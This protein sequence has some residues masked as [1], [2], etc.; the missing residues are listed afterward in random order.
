MNMAA[1]GHNQSIGA[2]GFSPFQWTR[3]SDAPDPELP[4]GIDPRKAFGGMLKLKAKAK[5]AFEMEYA[6][7]RMSKLSNATARP[8]AKF[9]TGTLVM[10][11]RQRMRPVK[12]SGH[13]VGPLRVLLQENN[14]LWLAT[15]ANIVKAKL[16]QVRVLTRREELQA[17]M[18]G[19]AVLK[20]PV[21]VESLLKDFTGKHYTNICGE[22]PSEQQRQMDVAGTTVLLEP[23]AKI[24]PDFWKFENGKWLIRIHNAPRLALFSPSR[25]T[26]IPMD[27]SNL[28]GL[29]RTYVRPLLEGAN[30]ML[31]ENNFEEVDDPHRLL[32]ER[33]I[34]ETWFEIKPKHEEKPKRSPEKSEQKDK[35][36][37]TQDDR[38][39]PGVFPEQAAPELDPQPEGD[40]LPPDGG[41][42]EA[43]H[44]KGPDAV[45]GVP[46][47][48]LGEA[49]SSTGTTCAI[50]DCVLP[51]GHYGPHM[52]GQNRRFG[53][54][55]YLGRT[56]WKDDQSSSDS[57]SSSSSD[58]ELISEKEM[59]RRKVDQ[60]HLAEKM[61]VEN[62]HHVYALEIDITSDDIKWISKHPQK[63]A[64]W[65][66][67]KVMEKGKEKQWRLLSQKEKLE[68]DE[69]QAKE[70]SQVLQSK[71]VRSLTC[72]EFAELDERTVMGMR[73]VLT[74][75]STGAAKARLV[76]LGYQAPGV[77][78]A[79]AASPTMSRLS[80]N[81]LFC[82]CAN[83]GF[84]VRGGD[85]TSAFLQVDDDMEGE[86]LTVWAPS[87][88]AVLFGAPPDNPVLPLRIL[89]AF[90]GLVTAP[91]AWF[92]HLARTLK[93][94]GWIQMSA[95]RCVFLLFD[96]NLPGSPLVSI[97]GVHVD[98]LLVGGLDD[99]EYFQT[100]FQALVESYKWGKWESDDFQ[101]TGCRVRQETNGLIRVDQQ[102]YTEKWIDEINLTPEQSQQ[103][104]SAATE[105]EVSALRGAIG[106]VAWRASQTAPQY[107]ADAGLLLSEIPF[108]TV[109]TIVRTNKLIREMKRESG[110]CIVFHP[111]NEDWRQIAVVAWADAGQKNRPDSSSTL[112]YIVGL[113]PLGI[114]SGEEAAVSLVNWRSSKTPRQV[115]GSNGAEVQAVTEAEDCVFHVRALWC[116]MH[117]IQFS[118]HNLYEVVRDNSHGAVVMD[119]RG[120]FDAATRNVSSLHGL[121]SSRAGYELTI[122]VSQAKR[123]GT[124]F[125]WVHG[126]VQ[127]GDCLTKFGSR[128]II[129]QFFANGQRWKR[130]YMT[131]NSK[132]DAV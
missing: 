68:F 43:L 15:G 7:Q 31:V 36:Q 38:P 27:V 113:A 94:L 33:W 24:A 63:S 88:L 119:T 59:K 130:L 66:S 34:G 109:N 120:I 79:K 129:L 40:L 16:N 83:K 102:E 107:M 39:A 23:S 104:K 96:H 44:E 61:D 126:G 110:Q 108:A 91:K 105:R 100:Q 74:T 93:K 64:I 51:G 99:N 80:R 4:A 76:V 35:K 6:K 32:Q 103:L 8:V 1:H 21:T 111:W 82:V 69:A 84:R 9:Q 117:G 13:W 50:P 53:W 12:T 60:A 114:L 52:D 26:N 37:K 95:D 56:E 22:N 90:Y 77:E 128:K 132:V 121:R 49:Q 42:Q 28:S 116:E 72:Q 5:V 54:G 86:N 123:V 55:P 46:A 10:V 118:R 125:R 3:G 89:R 92:D 85:A 29:R 17:S 30:E 124:V 106:T 62:E 14:T 19:T 81:M 41:L 45:D 11:W 57:S 78:H 71:A 115:M 131:P 2:N 75:K 101:F 127:L 87:E 112:G 67:R 18:E 70:L 122:S 98:D 25:T 48:T 97:I 20:M 47:R 65:M 73:W 58:E